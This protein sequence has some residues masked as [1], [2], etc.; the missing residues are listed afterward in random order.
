VYAPSAAENYSDESENAIEP[1]AIAGYNTCM[2]C[3][4]ENG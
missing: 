4:Y 3:V 2:Y 1:L